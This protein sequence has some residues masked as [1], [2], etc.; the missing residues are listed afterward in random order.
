MLDITIESISSPLMV[1][2]DMPLIVIA[3][4]TEH[5]PTISRKLFTVRFL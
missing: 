1:V 3:A 4:N 5:S 2:F